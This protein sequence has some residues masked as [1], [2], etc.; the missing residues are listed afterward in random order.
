MLPR[1]PQGRVSAT[2]SATHRWTGRESDWDCVCDAVRDWVGCIYAVERSSVLR[3]LRRPELPPRLH[4]MANP[5]YLTLGEMLRPW[6]RLL[7]NRGV[8]RLQD[9][10]RSVLCSQT[11]RRRDELLQVGALG[12]AQGVPGGGRQRR[13]VRRAP[14]AVPGAV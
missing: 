8:E 11:S 5:S 14:A 1:L 4:D 6:S 7:S 2:Q 10:A 13:R 12:A 9:A 3:L